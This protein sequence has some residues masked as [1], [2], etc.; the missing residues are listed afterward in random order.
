MNIILAYDIRGKMKVVRFS[1]ASSPGV[2][3][4]RARPRLREGILK[5][6]Q[7]P[8]PGGRMPGPASPSGLRK[9][10]GRSSAGQAPPRKE[11]D[12]R[13]APVGPAKRKRDIVIFQSWG[14]GFHSL[15]PP[16]PRKVFLLGWGT[17]DVFYAAGRN[18]CLARPH[19]EGPGEAGTATPAEEP[20]DGVE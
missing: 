16:S 17:T 5:D 20:G 8:V 9:E 10:K 4:G 19:A 6:L 15:P 3:L 14:H 2:P 13:Q 12:G 11:K 1:P 18:V 7:W